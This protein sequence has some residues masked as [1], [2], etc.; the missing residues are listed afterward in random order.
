MTKVTVYYLEMKSLEALRPALADRPG[1]GVRQAEIP[2][3]ELDRFLSTAVGVIDEG[4][5]LGLRPLQE[6]E[7]ILGHC[8]VCLQS[9]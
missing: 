6:G 9:W 4:K 7:E 2:S 5:E 8:S 1:L 3:P